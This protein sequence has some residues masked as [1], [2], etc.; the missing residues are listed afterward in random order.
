MERQAKSSKEIVPFTAFKRG[1]RWSLGGSVISCNPLGGTE[2][3][4]LLQSQTPAVDTKQP[5]R[6][7][8]DLEQL[9]RTGSASKAIYFFCSFLTDFHSIPSELTA[10]TQHSARMM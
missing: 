8:C 10:T 2:C 5:D 9:M 7:T 1:V 4:I 3:A 6:Y